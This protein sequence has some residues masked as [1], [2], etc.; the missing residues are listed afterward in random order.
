MIVARAPLRISLAGGGSD[1]PSFYKQSIGQVFSFTI[2]K[3]V[4]IA[5]HE[6]FLG[7]IRL[8]YSKTE[9]VKKIEDIEHPLIRE[10]MKLINFNE[11]IEIGSY[12]DVPGNGTG[13]GSS[14]AFCVALL[15]ALNA[16]KQIKI[17]PLYLAKTASEIEIIKCNEPIGKQD[18]F[19]TS[20]G[21][22]NHF[23]FNPNEDVLIER[24]F[25]KN[26]SSFLENSILLFYLGS[27]RESSQI[28]KAQNDAMVKN[29]T[30]FNSVKKISDKVPEMISAVKNMDIF[31]VSDLI[32]ESWENKKNL[33]K[34][35]SNDLI[36]NAI[37]HAK[38]NGALAAKVLGAGGGGFLMVT[39]EQHKRN[40]FLKN[41]CEFKNLSFKISEFGA[42]VVYD[43][44][45]INK[46]KI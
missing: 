44:E 2:D 25:N 28:L 6:Q 11:S 34:K 38:F 13:L 29:S 41:F 20:F 32:N 21:G 31:K 39:V 10:V 15:T 19:A 5:C 42:Q 33:N 23:I 46:F 3:Y 45:S 4:Y 16:Y 37:M 30:E 36:E 35:I 18:Q 17:G 27:G 43:D 40:S 22:I 7:G 26:I 12:A 24:H 9:N 8:S 14:S 1:L